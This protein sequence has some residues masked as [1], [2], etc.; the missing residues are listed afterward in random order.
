MLI[1]L[2]LGLSVFEAAG[3]DRRNVWGNLLGGQQTHLST[4]ESPGG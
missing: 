2:I 1:V 3:D 4:G